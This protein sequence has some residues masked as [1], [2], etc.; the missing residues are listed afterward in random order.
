MINLKGIYK[1]NNFPELE[2]TDPT[3]TVDNKVKE[4]DPENM[5]IHVD[6][7]IERTG[8]IK[9]RYYIDINPVPVSNLNYDGGELIQRVTERLADFKIDF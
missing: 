4:I 9:G 7:Y 3:I 1:F 8:D 5:T 6:A 2:F